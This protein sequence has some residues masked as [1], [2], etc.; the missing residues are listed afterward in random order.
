MGDRTLQAVEALEQGYARG[1]LG[2]KTFERRM[3]AIMSVP[4]GTDVRPLVADLLDEE[5]AWRRT[6]TALAESARDALPA[7]RLH[8]SPIAAH[9]LVSHARVVLGRGPACQ[10]VF[11][12][13]TVSR[14]HAELRLEDGVWHLRDLGSTNGTWV[15]GRRVREAEV[16]PGDEVR[17]GAVRFRL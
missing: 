13:E 16:R 1:A 14:R 3:A 2:T 4:A 6:L 8:P 11:A 17:L 7:P 9:P 10:V 5:P 12:E 15:N